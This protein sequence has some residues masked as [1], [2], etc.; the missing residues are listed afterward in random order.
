[1]LLQQFGDDF[2]AV[3][4]FFLKL[5]DFL[6]V[7]VLLP[8]HVGLVGTP[9]KRALGVLEKLFLSLVIL[10]GVDSELITQIGYRHVFEQV[11]ADDRY[12][13]LGG[14]LLALGHRDLLGVS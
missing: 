3:L 11:T 1:M 8:F 4:Q 2:V 14:I 10:C 9:R 12:L 13:L 5:P 7:R 6:F